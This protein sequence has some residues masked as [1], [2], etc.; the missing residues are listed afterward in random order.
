[1]ILQAM[2]KMILQEHAYKPITGKVLCL[3]PQEICMSPDEVDELLKDVP[4]LQPRSESKVEPAMHP[5]YYRADYFFSRFTTED[6][7]SLDVDETPSATFVHDLNNPIPDRLCNQYDFIVDGGTFDHLFNLGIALDNVTKMLKPGG[8]VFQYNAASNYLGKAYVM[9]GPNLFYD[10]YTLNGFTDCKVYIARE[11]VREV[12]APWEVFYLPNGHTKGLNC[13]KRKMVIVI[14]EK[15]HEGQGGALP[16]QGPYRLG[17]LVDEFDNLEKVT[18]ESERPILWGTIDPD[19]KITGNVK[20]VKHAQKLAADGGFSF[21]KLFRKKAA[22][23][24]NR[25]IKVKPDM[26][27]GNF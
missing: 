20:A 8:R 21:K 22:K 24:V 14:A 12:N 18:Q 11:T 7:E 1:M 16:V 2:A 26:Y 25:P 27:V 17:D 5:G 10:Y 19:I 9:F 4:N 13:E 15:G 3:G 23:D 6:L